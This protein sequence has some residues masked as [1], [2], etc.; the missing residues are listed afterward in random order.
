M[1]KVV[2]RQL[3]AHKARLITTFLAVA[4]GVAFIGGVLVLTDTMN[5]SFDD[6]FADVYRDTDAVVRS[7]ETIDTDFGELR[8]RIDASLLDTVRSADGVADADGSVDGFARVIDR[9]GDP[10]GNPEMGAPTLGGSWSDV[11]ALNPF[12]LTDGRGPENDGEI[13]IDL[14]TA[15]DTDF[16]VGDEVQVQTQTVAETYEVVGVV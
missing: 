16:G 6:L 13:V 1:I 2:L 10:V 7:D 15:K 5:R 14:G 4:L 9:S 12:D 11:D 8:G 3:L